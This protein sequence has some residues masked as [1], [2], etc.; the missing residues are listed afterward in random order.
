M[1]PQASHPE[2]VWRGKRPRADR[3][4]AASS[5]AVRE[6]FDPRQWLCTLEPDVVDSYRH[7]GSWRNRLIA[8]DSLH[9]MQALAEREGLRGAVQCVFFDPPYGIS[10]ERSHKLDAYRDTWQ[11]G[12]NGY[13]G[14]LE[15]RLWAARDLLCASGS[16]FVQIGE[17]NSH[18]VRCLL[19][20]VLGPENFVSD[21]VFR[22]K[23]MPLGARFL[24]CMVDH[25]LWYAKDA[26][27]LKYRQ[28]YLPQD[29]QGDFHWKWADGPG[30]S[31][32]LT[33]EQNRDHGLL[34]AGSRVFR[35]VSM[36]APGY[37][38]AND[39]EV[40]FDG[41]RFAPPKGGSWITG[42]E[43]MARLEAAG[44][45]FVEGR[46][47]V[48]KLYLDDFPLV[49]LTSLWADTVGPSGKRYVVQT[50]EEVVQR[51]LLMATDPGDLVLDP[52][53]GSGTTA[54]VAERWGRRWIAIDTSPMAIALSRS[55]LWRARH[56]WHKLVGPSDDPAQGF[57]YERL[58]RTTLKT[59]AQQVPGQEVVLFDRPR[60]ARGRTRV[61]SP[62]AIET[63]EAPWDPRAQVEFA[64]LVL[65]HLAKSGFMGADRQG[66]IA[67]EGL[68]AWPGQRIS[69]AG[70]V[71]M[72][73]TERRAAVHVGPRLGPIH[74]GDLSLAAREAL[75]ANFDLLIACGF[76]FEPG[77]PTGDGPPGLAIL[78]L[79]MNADLLMAD[80]LE[81]TGKTGL[82]VVLGDLDL[83]IL[84][85]PDGRLRVRL[86]GIVAPD[87][88]TGSLWRGGPASMA[89]W[90]VD[91]DHQEGSFVVRQAFHLGDDDPYKALKSALKARISPQ[92]WAQLASDTCGP[93][94]RPS[95]GRLA[96]KAVTPQGDELVKVVQV[97]ETGSRPENGISPTSARTALR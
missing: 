66:R 55:R 39:F 74:P 92:T 5:L 1:D 18:L 89:S 45:L 36:K 24:D 44:R 85:D 63:L 62:F 82:F 46:T 96:V 7:G 59:V 19:D 76:E 29:V 26:Q 86:C 13:L 22:K 81:N 70:R 41:K 78:G 25:L 20:D 54:T 94:G 91:T 42:P 73:G 72:G 65:E 53:S 71:A 60:V 97:S 11:D 17:K 58:C 61:S 31:F 93:F 48:Y 67:V 30:G 6:R 2:L 43:G 14:H 9:A 69:G 38:P 4:S 64:R 77:D 28:L 88:A 90:F 75:E 79:K 15:D 37:S 27:H 83:E 40:E 49:K 33:P 52:T 68:T 12:L 80:R 51:C 87:L 16:I 21:I 8:G 95:S 32:K 3:T 56:P 10:Y 34:P 50:S 84:E 57:E 47:L 23:T 35:V